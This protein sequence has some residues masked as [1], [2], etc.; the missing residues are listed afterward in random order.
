VD[1][2]NWSNALISMNGSVEE[3]DVTDDEF[4]SKNFTGIIDYVAIKTK[5]FTTAIIP[6]P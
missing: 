2:S 1:E 6:Q 4:E 5:Y 3:F